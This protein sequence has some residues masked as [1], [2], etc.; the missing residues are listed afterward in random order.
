MSLTDAQEWLNQRLEFDLPLCAVM[1]Q[2]ECGDETIYRMV[3]TFGDIVLLFSCLLD[4]DW[5]DHDTA[6]DLAES[7]LGDSRRVGN[8]NYEITRAFIVEK[9]T[10]YRVIEELDIDSPEP[11]I[12]PA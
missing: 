5:T 7:L 4:A 9:E 3:T 10:G 2:L 11:Y 8:K 1:T 6:R 12:P